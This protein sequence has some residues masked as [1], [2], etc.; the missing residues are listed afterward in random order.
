MNDFADDRGLIRLRG[1]ATPSDRSATIDAARRSTLIR[2][3]RGVYIHYEAWDQLDPD[4]RYRALVHAASGGLASDE[5]L[6][7]PSALALWR[8]PTIDGWPSTVHSVRPSRGGGRHSGGLIRHVTSRPDPGEHIDGLPVTSLARTVSDVSAT[9]SLAA[10]LMAADAAVRGSSARALLRAPLDQDLLL[11]EAERRP[12]RHG[13][14]RALTVAQLAD[15]RAESPG[16]SLLRASIHL[17]GLPQPELQWEFRGDSGRRYFVDCYWP[18]QDFVLEFDGRAKYLDPA[19]RGGRTAEE[20]LVAEKE[21]ED[22]I[23]ARVRGM[24]RAGW[25]VA[26]APVR[27]AARLRAA[28]FLFPGRERR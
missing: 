2:L 4:A 20:V 6:C 12:V 25:A 15:A 24:A 13:R 5:L 1:I 18:D 16:E 21:R 27:L 14:T 9:R 11:Q 26:L 10:G 17:L 3:A 28:G 19:L 8:L 23:R 22:E 7:G